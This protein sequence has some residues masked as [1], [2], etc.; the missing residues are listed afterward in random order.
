MKRMV[1]I[2]EYKLKKKVLHHKQ[3]SW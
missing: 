3:F 2:K 1:D